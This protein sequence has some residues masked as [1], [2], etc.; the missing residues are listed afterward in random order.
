[1]NPH[2]RWTFAERTVLKNVILQVTYNGRRMNWSTIEK[3]YRE[4][5]QKMGHPDRSVDGLKNQWI[6]MNKANL[7][8]FNYDT[9][10]ASHSGWYPFAADT[11]QT[12]FFPDLPMAQA[13]APHPGAAILS[14]YFNFH[15]DTFLSAATDPDACLP[16]QTVSSSTPPIVD[17]MLILCAARDRSFH[18]RR[19]GGSQ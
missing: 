14:P 12:T 4:K 3:L 19:K 10:V 5:V 11:Y 17:P 15:Q 16:I 6:R 2:P 9:P 18:R 1:M 8:Q 7:P 13:T